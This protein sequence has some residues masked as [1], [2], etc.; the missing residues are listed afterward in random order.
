MGGILDLLI[1][2]QAFFVH[3]RTQQST[4]DTVLR[5]TAKT[6]S[7]GQKQIGAFWGPESGKVSPAFP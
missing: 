6:V 1:K 4:I 5:L 7:T 3:K 2:S